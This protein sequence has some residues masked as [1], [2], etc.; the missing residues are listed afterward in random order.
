MA[1]KYSSFKDQVII[2]RDE[3]YNN[4][5]V[6]SIYHPTWNTAMAFFEGEQWKIWS[7][8]DKQLRDFNPAS[9]TRRLVV[10]RVEKIVT[11]FVAHFIREL[12][13]F[14]VN[15]NSNTPDDKNA[16]DMSQNVL[17]VEYA[18]KLEKALPEYFYWKYIIGTGIR[19]L[20]WDEKAAAEI[21]LPQYG[22]NGEVTNKTVVMVPEVGQLYIKTINPFNFYPVGGTS[23]EDCTEILYIEPMSLD[24]IES[25]YDF[26]AQEEH[27]ETHM[28]STGYHRDYQEDHNEEFE[29]RAKVYHYWR[30]D[31]KGFPDGVYCASVNK[32]ILEYRE[33]PYLQYGY[34]FPFFKSCAIP[35]PGQFWGKSPVEQIRRTQICYNYVYSLIIQTMERMGKLKW[36]VPKQANVDPNAIDSKIGEFCYY[37]AA[38]GLPPPNQANLSPLPY[39]YF[40]VLE[41]LDKAFEDI[42]GFHE[43]KSARLPT[44]ANNPSG[45]MVNL[46]LE[47]DETRLAPAIK[48]YTASLKGEAKLYLK[49]VQ[50]L[51]MEE[52]VLKIMGVE[53]EAEIQDFRGSTLKDN[54]D[55][56]VEIA[57]VLSEGRAAWEQTV[58]KAV[59]LGVMD[60][61]TAVQKL[62]LEHPKAMLDILADER[63]ALRE[64]IEM[65]NGV[66]R[67]VQEWESDDAHLNILEG[68]LKTAT[69]EHLP[70]DVQQIFLQHRL[71]HQQQQAAKFQQ[72]L[73]AMQQ[74]QQAQA[75][76][77]PEQEAQAEVDAAQQQANAQAQPQG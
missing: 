25:R 71:M 57:P 20:F 27:L 76:T 38:P 53:K 23:I 41:W 59:E 63:L 3:I 21:Q 32:E 69:Y 43:V 60:G 19:G 62:K 22:D 40:Q 31:S 18:D 9:L 4:H 46:L 77:S 10:N 26:E 49:M 24:E 42:T 2:R 8:I 67:G 66:Q 36:W 56:Q 11:T 15:P 35:V 5:S 17:Q 75:G 72:K 37:N 68:F 34:R 44:G 16:A 14:Y 51:Y 55:V 7:K 45:V 12:P 6:K 70:E 65:R 13:T 74:M 47:Q 61:R 52:R 58:F 39:Y 50:E 48:Q 28:G 64:N 29:K 1:E 73:A 30:A 33:N 54:N